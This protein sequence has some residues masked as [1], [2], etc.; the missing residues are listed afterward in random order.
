[1]NIIIGLLLVF[2]YGVAPLLVECA[3]IIMTFGVLFLLNH[4]A[5]RKFQERYSKPTAF[6]LVRSREFVEHIEKSICSYLKKADMYNEEAMG[7]IMEKLS[8]PK[9]NAVNFKF[10]FAV[11][12]AL[13]PLF[14][15]YIDNL[16]KN[17]GNNIVVLIWGGVYSMVFIIM[18]WGV[19]KV[20]N[21]SAGSKA[22]KQMKL[23]VVLQE[24]IYV[25][26]S[27]VQGQVVK[28]YGE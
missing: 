13:L 22:G 20:M 17:S 12:V 26:R 1:M 2:S 15:L 24:L 19:T 25:E 10:A 21:L 3:F 9:E 23:Q 18:I 27:E 7:V 5:K 8:T 14:Y 4:E 16:F 28:E 11:G 6:L